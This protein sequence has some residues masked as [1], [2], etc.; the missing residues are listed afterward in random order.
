MMKN[1]IR[2]NINHTYR[3][4]LRV[5]LIF[6]LIKVSIIS[7]AQNSGLKTGEWIRKWLL[8]GPFLLEECPDS[9]RHLPGFDYDFL[10]NYGGE[11]NPSV[12]EGQLV[13]FNDVSVHWMNY[14]SPD[15]IINLDQTISEENF[16]SAY[17]YTE[18]ESETEGV[19]Y[20][21]LGADD[22]IKLWFNGEKVWDHPQKE[23]GI[24]RDDELIPVKVCVGK[25]TILLKVEE[26]KGAWGFNAR[27]LP[28]DPAE[29]VNLITL[30]HVHIKRD[31]IPELRLSRKDIFPEKLFKKVLLEIVDENSKNT[32]WQGEW[33]KNQNMILPVENGKY[34]NNRLIISAIFTDG[35]VWEKKI[36]FNSG[37]PVQYKLFDNGK[38]DYC[39]TIAHD[40]SESEQWAAKELQHWLIKICGVPFPIKTDAEEITEHEII[41]GYNR[42]S[43]AFLEP[44][45]RQPAETDESYLYK[46][47]G[48]T[49][50]L[51]GG[52]KRGSMYSVFSF[53]ENEMGC[54]WYTPAVSIIPSKTYFTFSCLN[55]KESP[56][57]RVRNDFYYEAFDPVW[58]ARNKINGAM[59]SRSQIG[60]VE[61]YWG[62]HTFNR[63]VPPSEFFGDH[64]EFFSLINGK[65]TCDRA[66]LCLTNTAV[67]DI[68]TERLKKVMVEEPECLIYC[69]S[70]NDCRNPCQCEN[71]QAI[72][73]NEKSEAGPVIWFVNQVAERIKD[74]FPGKYVGTLAYQYTRKPPATMKPL[75]NVVVRF[76]SI[77][78]CFA[79]DFKSC[80]ENRKFLE[81]LKGWAAVAPHMY[82]WDYAVSFREY[83]LP[84]PNF[85]VI[86]SNIKTFLD[87]NAIGIMEQ[88]AY[89]CR[90]TEFAELRAYLIAKLLWNAEADVDKII[91]DFM[92]G[93]YGRSG[94]YVRLY[95]NLLHG[96]LTPETHIYIGAKGLTYNNIFL[97]DE[98]IRKAE[99]IFDIAEQVADNVEI[100]QRVEMARLPVMYLKCKMT[101]VQA[102]IDGTYDRFCQILDR[103]GITHLSEKGEP[104]VE[105]FHLH[106]K[107]A[108]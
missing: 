61:G 75:D 35:G 87:N 92:A 66:Q 95:F 25:N 65:R 58:A 56:S 16:V 29:L 89:Q 43:L 17:A 5:I 67:L 8:A 68:V 83:M 84:F 19:Y 10:I 78:C 41:I 98:F 81:D 104:D 76:C 63:F 93:Y 91:D 101:P 42:H 18:I 94:Q 34:K 59:G 11:T 32:T 88:A 6:F 48:P 90:G 53:L 52:E 44:G 72:A 82:I 22:G 2:N 37:I 77:E 60:G 38:T 9:D 71:C 47:V 100:F 54:R 20:F 23:H 49:L 31:G 57:V 28:S 64:P 96:L 107:N 12:K 26:R 80:P 30:F 97:T 106:V 55:H 15:A 33:N 40:A 69:V 7:L 39:I 4:T 50:L 1:Q 46:N 105:R 74:E 62:V 79:H 21:S 103:E 13:N 102:K 3:L 86:Q 108:E 27:I 24:R 99:E 70:Q 73:K 36:P 45:T 51:L 85:N 14:E